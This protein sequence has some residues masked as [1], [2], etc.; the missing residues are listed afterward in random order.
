MGL[1][2]T[3]LVEPQHAAKSYRDLTLITRDGFTLITAHLSQF[4]LERYLKL[5][6][7]SRN[8]LI[9]LV[10]EMIRNAVTNVDG[11]CWN[12]MRQAAGGNYL[13]I[14]NFF[15]NVQFFSKKMFK[16]LTR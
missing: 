3:I 15:Y 9:W 7:V 12:L 14:K 10:R 16:F 5:Q 1:V 11:V 2:Y 8:Q 13:L 6:E 4:I